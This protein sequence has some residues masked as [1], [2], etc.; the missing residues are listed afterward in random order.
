VL[1][2]GNE[3]MDA[4]LVKP[5]KPELLINILEEKLKDK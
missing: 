5:I 1:N 2:E 4:F 3:Y